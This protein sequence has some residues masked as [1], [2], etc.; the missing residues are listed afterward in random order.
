MLVAVLLLALLFNGCTGSFSPYL[1]ERPYQG[2]IEVIKS[3]DAD[4]AL[5]EIE[6]TAHAYD[7]NKDWMNAHRAYRTAALLAEALGNYQK[8]LT[9]ARKSYDL[10]EQNFGTRGLQP[11]SLRFASHLLAQAHLAVNDFESVLPLLLKV[12][13]RRIPETRKQA[14]VYADLHG[15]LGDAYQ[16]RGDLKS[17]LRHHEEAFNVQER[18]LGEVNAAKSLSKRK[19]S[20]VP[21]Q[22]RDRYLRH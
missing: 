12:L 1:V 10:A 4:E 2:A 9:Y 5:R 13:P 3:G 18:V 21:P 6:A 7:T 8:M 15:T 22:V 14:Q 17:A 11:P 16:R 19:S 20:L